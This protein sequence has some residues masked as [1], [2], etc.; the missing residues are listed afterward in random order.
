MPTY[1]V[2][3]KSQTDEHRR[4]VR[5]TCDDEEAAKDRCR[6][7]EAEYVAYSVDDDAGLD[8]QGRARVMRC[9]VDESTQ[10]VAGGSGRDRA[11]YHMHHQDK[12]YRI[13]SVTEEKN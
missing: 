13:T 4:H 10:K 8:A 5:V 3:L 6:E 2:T 11:R 7:L 12:P 9:G 1:L